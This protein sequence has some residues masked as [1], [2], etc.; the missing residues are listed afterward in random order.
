M[1]NNRGF[2]YPA[3]QRRRKPIRIKKMGI[4]YI[5]GILLLEGFHLRQ[6]RKEHRP[7]IHGHADFWRHEIPRMVHLNSFDRLLRDGLRKLPAKANLDRWE[8]WDWSDN[9]HFASCHSRKMRH[10]LFDEYSLIRQDIIGVQRS[11]NKN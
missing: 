5:K 4:N 7:S 1:D 6:Q 11:E 9:L 8:I 10:A 2:Q 3:Q